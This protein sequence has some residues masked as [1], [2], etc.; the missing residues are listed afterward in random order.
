MIN[1]D[2]FLNW[3][4]LKKGK[5]INIKL[6]GRIFGC[7]FGESP[8]LVRDFEIIDE[9]ILKI[10]FATTEVLEIIS[11]VLIEIGG[12]DQLIVK[13]A[14]EVLFG[15]HYYGRPQNPENWCTESYKLID[16]KVYFESKGP[17]NTDKSVY[18][19]KSNSLVE[20]I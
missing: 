4:S 14:D 17:L 13:S 5:Y 15:W 8:Q 16:D 18:P 3:Y 2:V 6:G 19:L 20:L 9:R 7:R 11:P 12:Y 10:R 1:L